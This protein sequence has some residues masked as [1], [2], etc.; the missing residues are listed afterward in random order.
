[1]I[2]YLIL[3]FMIVIIYFFTNNKRISNEKLFLWL[4]FFTLFVFA[5]IRSESTGVDLP[6]YKMYFNSIA[7]RPL[8]EQLKIGYF[9][10]GFIV[11]VFLI[12][13]L[14]GGNFRLLL[15]ITSFI[16]Y[17][18]VFKFINNYSKNK[19]LSIIIYICI[20]YYISPFSGLRQCIAISVVCMGYK[21][22]VNKN[23][24]KFVFMIIIATLFHKSALIFI[25]AYW[26]YNFDISGLKHL[27]MLILIPITYIFRV[28]IILFVESTMY[29]NYGVVENAGSGY[30]L[31]FLYLCI[32][33]IITLFKKKF[34]N[35]DKLNNFMYNCFY[36]GIILQILAIVEGNAYR[37]TKYY[38]IT[39]LCI[40]PNLVNI[41]SANTKKSVIYTTI[42]II[43][44]IF[45][46]YTNPNLS[47]SIFFLES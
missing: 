28:K 11:Y 30:K 35:N 6:T 34:V 12:H 44:L 29:S 43:S 15:V 37:A 22:I 18:G 7:I 31:L 45:F 41:F 25:P 36:I 42:F 27:F 40:I 39:L 3:I 10:K 4:S 33:F 17:Y 8:L 14:T 20:G 23:F 2:A 32:M 13:R 1:M 21:Y 46:I 38:L 5:A 26:L 47:Y 24:G 16:S 19:L 9:E